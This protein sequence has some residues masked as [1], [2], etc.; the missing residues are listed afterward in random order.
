VNKRT[1]QAKTAFLNSATILIHEVVI[2]ELHKTRH[3]LHKKIVRAAY[4]IDY[5]I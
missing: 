5:D 2:D 3:Y 1:P 4:Q